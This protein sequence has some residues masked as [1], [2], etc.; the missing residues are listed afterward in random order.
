[1][2]CPLPPSR[3]GYRIDGKRKSATHRRAP[4]PSTWWPE[5]GL[6][7]SPVKAAL[8]SPPPAAIGLDTACHEAFV[9]HQRI[10]G[11]IR[12]PRPTIV[13]AWLLA[14]FR[15]YPQICLATGQAQPAMRH[16]IRPASGPIGRPRT[17]LSCGRLGSF[18][19][20]L[21]LDAFGFQRL[22]DQAS[23]CIASCRRREARTLSIFI[24]Q[25]KPVFVSKQIDLLSACG[26]LGDHVFRL[27]LNHPGSHF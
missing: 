5:Y 12:P 1:M 13:I 20:L 23:D 8:R 3:E 16:Q 27:P 21:W 10:D 9:C 2:R 24:D 19:R 4:P 22:I 6:V 18:A 26:E 15:F 17:C 11:G 25:I 7:A 14:T